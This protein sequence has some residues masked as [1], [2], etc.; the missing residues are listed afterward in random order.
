MHIAGQAEQKIVSD[1]PIRKVALCDVLDPARTRSMLKRESY[2][3]CTQHDHKA[4]DFDGHI[5]RFGD[6]GVDIPADGYVPMR[7]RR[8]SVR[9][10]LPKIIVERLTGLVFGH[11]HFPKIRALGDSVAEDYVGALADVAKLRSRM[12]EAR[13][14]GGATGTAV[15][16]WGFVG[17]KPL[18]EV[19]Q[20]AFVEVLEWRDYERRKPLK[21]VKTYPYSKRVWSADGKPQDVTVHYARYWDE[22]LDISWKEIPDAL[23]KTKAW[24]RVPATIVAHGTGYCPVYWVQNIP[25]SSSVDGVSDFEGQ[26]QTS[27]ETIVRC[28]D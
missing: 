5:L 13:N 25:D 28:R 3:R 17:G 21:V 8:P 11:G 2:F 24:W 16:S 15:L 27:A 10:D 22:N 12:V 1:I 7:R 20:S 19:H 23:A 18:V 26:E 4:Y 9:M 14:I 6:E